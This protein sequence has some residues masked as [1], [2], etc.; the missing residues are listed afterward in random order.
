MVVE[1]T[2]A[3]AMGATLGALPVEEPRSSLP[4]ALT[5]GGGGSPLSPVGAGGAALVHVVGL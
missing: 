5:M 4:S 3:K 2:L 1:H